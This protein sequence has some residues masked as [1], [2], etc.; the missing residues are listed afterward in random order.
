MEVDGDPVTIFKRIK[1]L[2]QLTN[3]WMFILN[4]MF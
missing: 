4:Y 3:Q 1:R 2:I